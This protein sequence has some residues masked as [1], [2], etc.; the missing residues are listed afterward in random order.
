MRCQRI[1]SERSVPT[2]TRTA[3]T[4]SVL[5]TFAAVLVIFGCGEPR[6]TPETT[7]EP[8]PAPE[9]TDTLAMKG[10]GPLF[11]LLEKRRAELRALPGRT[12]ILA[13]DRKY[14]LFLEELIIRDFFGDKHSGFFVDV[15]CAWPIES[16]NTY[17][18]EKH[19]GWEGI[20][21]DAL[22]DYAPAW[23][24]NR[25]NSKFFA[26][27]VTDKSGTQETFFK[28]P[29]FGLSSTNKRFA[30][31]GVFGDSMEP[32]Q[33]L[34]PSITLNDLLDREGVKKIDLLAMDIEGHEFTALK[35]F[36]FERFQPALVVAE[37][38]LRE[39]ADRSPLEILF[40]E[41]GYEL[42]ERYLPFDDLNRYYAPIGTASSAD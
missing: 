15:G 21:I 24:E 40:E 1:R 42:L 19:L 38:G 9:Q 13:Q 20:G 39:G 17:Y 25:P 10:K 27:L 18:L 6:E 28:S 29:N 7:Q 5:I 30:S 23:K 2:A 12:G 14:S 41:N 22:S 8:S 4:R 26:Y 11:A 36:D 34:V 35:G 33:I 32:E 16:N 3:T 37:Q 31:G